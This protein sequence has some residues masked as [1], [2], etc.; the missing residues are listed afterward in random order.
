MTLINSKLFSKEE[1]KERNGILLPVVEKSEKEKDV[2]IGIGGRDLQGTVGQ[3]ERWISQNLPGPF[4][5]ILFI[6][7]L[8]PQPLHGWGVVWPKVRADGGLCIILRFQ[9]TMMSLAGNSP[10]Q[11][12]HNVFCGRHVELVD[13]LFSAS[14]AV[15][16]TKYSVNQ[17]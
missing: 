14:D 16:T 9:A 2:C 15:A 7:F 4:Y 10:I 8:F 3:H 5:F 6:Y 12:A 13:W 1:E 17:T 11:Q